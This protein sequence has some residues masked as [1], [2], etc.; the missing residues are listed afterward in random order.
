MHTDTMYLAGQSDLCCDWVSGSAV[1]IARV[2]H[3][4]AYGRCLNAQDCA[5]LEHSLKILEL[6]VPRQSHNAN[7][8]AGFLNPSAHVK[9]VHC[10][11]LKDHAGFEIAARQKQGFGGI[12]SFEIADGIDSVSHLRHLKLVICAVSLGGVETTICQ[13]VAEKV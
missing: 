10:P 12:R 7:I 1:L 4:V 2:S 5:L 13:P 9:R 6:R 11:S 3:A 8:I